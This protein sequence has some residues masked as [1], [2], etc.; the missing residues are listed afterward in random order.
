MTSDASGSWGCGAFTSAGEWFQIE[1]LESWA[2]VHITVKELLPIV[3]G[4]AVWGHQWRGQTVTCRCDNAAVVAIVKSGRS[5]MERVMHL[6]RSLFFFT[7]RWNVVLAC[8]HI[9][10]VDNGAV[11]V[12][13]R[14]NLPS[15]QS[16]VPGSQKGAGTNLRTTA[17]SPSTGTT[18]PGH[19]E[20]D[21]LVHRFFLKG[22]AE[23]TLRTLWDQGRVGASTASES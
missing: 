17:E 14:N 12:L 8:T 15:F 2:G 1:L 11:D 5:K 7:A 21:N 6:M 13:S 10:G 23:V 3:I 19:G 22:L 9:P 18:G 4:V 20:L 16:L